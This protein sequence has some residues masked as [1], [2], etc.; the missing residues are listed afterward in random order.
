VDQAP[1]SPLDLSLEAPLPAPRGPRL[2]GPHSTASRGLEVLL[3]LVQ[4]ILVCGIPTQIVVAVAFFV[5]DGLPDLMHPSLQFVAMT[6]LFDTALV[7]ILLRVFLA[8]SGETS[9]EVFVGPRRPLGEIAKGL[10]FVPVT[11]VAVQLLAYG[12]RTAIPSL[13]NVDEN[14]YKEYM[15]SP[16]EAAIFIVVVILAGGLREEL[17]RAFIIRRFDQYLGGARVGLVLFSLLFGALHWPQ[18]L[19]AAIVIGLLGLVYGIVY[20]RRQSA[21]LTI[22]NHAG[23]DVSMVLLQYFGRALGI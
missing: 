7:A 3:A 19:D 4:V 5:T 18:G 22:T 1:D 21:V 14:P 2:L 8:V 17:Q 6:S 13:H 23:F 9:G 12:L 10:A 16:I 20:I 11:I 15:R